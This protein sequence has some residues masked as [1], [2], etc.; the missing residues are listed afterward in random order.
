MA[1]AKEA[2]GE[3]GIVEQRGST[4]PPAGTSRGIWWIVG[5][6]GFKEKSCHGV[7]KR[8]RK[9]I[10]SNYNTSPRLYSLRLKTLLAIIALINVFSITSLFLF[11]VLEGASKRCKAWR[12][13]WISSD[14]G[15][16]SISL[17]V[18]LFFLNFVLAFIF[19]AFRDNRL[20]ADEC[21]TNWTKLPVE[22]EELRFRYSHCKII[23]L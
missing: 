17:A 5:G 1:R 18:F 22:C 6:R 13:N 20:A 23:F 15:D 11:C 3:K 14:V 2:T 10:S 9:T 7:F 12:E 4:R 21:W 8:T 16:M 19:P